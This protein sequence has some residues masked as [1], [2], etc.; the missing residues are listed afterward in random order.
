LRWFIHKFSTAKQ[1]R[2]L[3]KQGH[4]IVENSKIC[5]S[6]EVA[7][8]QDEQVSDEPEVSQ[9]HNSPG[10]TRLE[11][12]VSGDDHLTCAPHHAQ[13]PSLTQARQNRK[14]SIFSRGM[15]PRVF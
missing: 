6:P 1:A 2:R 14:T 11:Q 10:D 3:K 4:R 9:W 13:P 8:L 7:V 5:L 15:T 12:D